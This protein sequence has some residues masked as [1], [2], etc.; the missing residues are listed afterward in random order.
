MNAP[1]VACTLADT[2]GIIA[3]EINLSM[4]CKTH[5]EWSDPINGIEAGWFTC[6]LHDHDKAFSGYGDTPSRALMMANNARLSY[7]EEL[8]A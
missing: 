6:W 7:A 1:I 8:A 2:L 5:I 3:K 4:G